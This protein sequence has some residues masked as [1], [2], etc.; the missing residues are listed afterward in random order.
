M[1]QDHDYAEVAFP[2]ASTPTG[3]GTT[4]EAGPAAPPTA[5]SGTAPS[6]TN[7]FVKL[8]VTMPYSKAEFDEN[9]QELYKESI[10]SA[11]G[12]SVRNV[13]ILGIT[14]A[15]RRAGSINVETKVPSKYLPAPLWLLS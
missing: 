14:E 13:E 15:R 9:K 7:Y 8:V 12:T 11:S 5:D 3:L 4:V 10:A 1:T 6:N 2:T